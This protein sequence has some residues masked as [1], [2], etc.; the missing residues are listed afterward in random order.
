MKKRVFGALILSMFLLLPLYG[1]GQA[2]STADLAGTWYGHV[3]ATDNEGTFWLSVTF[4]VDGA[5]NVTGGSFTDSGGEPG[6]IVGGSLALDANGVVSGALAGQEGSIAFPHGKMDYRKQIINLVGVDNGARLSYGVL[7]KGGGAFSGA[8]LAGT[9]H[10]YFIE[11]DPAVGYY[12]A[13]GTIT[14]NASGNVTGGNF[15]VPDGTTIGVT[16]GSIAMDANGVS[17]GTITDAT[18]NTG[19]FEGK[20]DPGKGIWS[21]VGKDAGGAVNLGVA[22]KAGGAFSQADGAGAWH[23]HFYIIDP[24]VG[25]YWAY[26]LFT[27]DAAGN[28]TGG[29]YVGPDGTAISV[30]GG[31]MAI[32]ANGL[33]GGSVTTSDGGVV[34]FPQG[35]LDPGKGFWSFVGYDT[36]SALN[37]GIAIKQ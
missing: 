33:T 3:F 19:I 14:L 24:A 35:K 18:G 7:I 16:G 29:S 4:T 22:V 25:F 11:Y 8:D 34:T 31:T 15:T 26:G 6:V 20:L 9:W 30:T 5:G 23:A 28:V 1:E 37:F 32:D 2:F 10:L 13:F 36:T 21:F 12:W 27:M 17:T